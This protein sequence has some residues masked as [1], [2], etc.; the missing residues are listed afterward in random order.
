MLIRLQ[1][2]P[3]AVGLAIHVQ[4]PTWHTS[5]MQQADNAETQA[6]PRAAS[7]KASSGPSQ[8][9][10][11][12]QN[13]DAGT[14]SNKEDL[15][16]AGSTGSWIR[17]TAQYHSYE[18][19]LL[20]VLEWYGYVHPLYSPGWAVRPVLIMSF[21]FGWLERLAART[22][23]PLVQV[24]R[25]VLFY[26]METQHVRVVSQRVG[27]ALWWSVPYQHAHSMQWVHHKRSMCAVR[28]KQRKS[29]LHAAS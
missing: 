11:D 19:V 26:A 3:H 17:S 6:D 7:G 22:R 5:L 12:S 15:K 20:D 2:Q 1:E 4:S 27:Q 14:C 29:M 21:E 9:G 18:D 25:C 24:L 13:S 28:V 8:A 23:A 16:T 10:C